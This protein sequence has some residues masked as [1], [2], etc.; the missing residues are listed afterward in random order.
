MA[1]SEQ[2]EEMLG[3]EILGI[4]QE[5]PGSAIEVLELRVRDVCP[6][7]SVQL[8]I[9]AQ[10]EL[11]EVSFEYKGPE[12]SLVSGDLDP[13]RVEYLGFLMRTHLFEWWDTKDTEK[14]SERMG[15]RLN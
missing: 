5:Y 7:L 12:A 1:T 14:A 10:G 11:W 3:R 8:K 15:K 9:R 4:Q 6:R 13:D 2:V